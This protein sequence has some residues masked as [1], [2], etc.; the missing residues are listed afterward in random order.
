MSNFCSTGKVTSPDDLDYIC[1][2]NKDDWCRVL[3]SE[4][5]SF[6][7]IPVACTPIGNLE[8][9]STMQAD[10][11]RFPPTVVGYLYPNSLTPSSEY[12]AVGIGTYYDSNNSLVPVRSQVQDVNFAAET[13]WE[14]F[15]TDA[16]DFVANCAHSSNPRPIYSGVSQQFQNLDVCGTMFNNPTLANQSPYQTPTKNQAPAIPL[17]TLR[18]P[19]SGGTLQTW[20]WVFLITGIVVIFLM[21]LIV[22]LMGLGVF[23]A[24]KTV[25]QGYQDV[26]ISQTNVPPPPLEGP[27]SLGGQYYL[28][29]PSLAPGFQ[30]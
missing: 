3:L 19:I 14:V 1:F 4:N 2:G 30:P 22:A 7:E 26:A 16:N 29:R 9:S 18:V 24:S 11:I 27:P 15:S 23:S 28:P 6:G 25:Y 12:T 13:A 20:I 17:P 5:L 10:K 8:F 21:I